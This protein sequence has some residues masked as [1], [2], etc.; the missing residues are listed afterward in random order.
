ME[1]GGKHLGGLDVDGHDD[2]SIWIRLKALGVAIDKRLVVEALVEHELDVDV[3]VTAHLHGLLQS[4]LHFLPI[5]FGLV[6]W[7]ERDENV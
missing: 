7:N 1:L 4:L 2:D 3:E 5:G 6:L